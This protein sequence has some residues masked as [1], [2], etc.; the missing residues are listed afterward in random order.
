MAKQQNNSPAAKP[1]SAKDTAY[2]LMIA[3][4]EIQN[5][6]ERGEDPAT[7]DEIRALYGE[8]SALYEMLDA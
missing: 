5:E 3:L 6:M 7:I 2:G 4:G 8:A 1:Q